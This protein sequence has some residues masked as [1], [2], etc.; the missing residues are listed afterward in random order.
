M[1]T[2][3]AIRMIG[4]AAFA[5]ALVSCGA[6]L[7][8][9]DGP[10]F[11]RVTGVREGSALNV[12][13]GPGLEHPRIGSLPFDADGIRNLGCEGGLS[14]A[15]WEAASPAEREAARYSRWCRVEHGATAGWALG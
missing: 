14:F 2:S 8:E 6:A 1:G 15:E 9:A 7:A 13:A 4:L 10:D 12:R 11:F 3:P 5:A